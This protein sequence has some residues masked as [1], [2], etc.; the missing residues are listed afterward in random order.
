VRRAVRRA[1]PVEE[2]DGR[3]V[4]GGESSITGPA[5]LRLLGRGGN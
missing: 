5:G 4:E 3:P 1:D 2:L